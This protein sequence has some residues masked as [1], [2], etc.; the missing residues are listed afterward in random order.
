MPELDGTVSAS[1]TYLNLGEFNRTENDPTVIETFK[2]YEFAVTA[3]YATKLSAALGIGVNGRFIHSRLAPFG[4]AQEKGSGVSSGFSF[5]VGML[6]K[7]RSLEIP[8]T[9]LDIGNRFSL[10]LNLT[11]IVPVPHR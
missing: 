6:Y 10:G 8:F 4:T 2:G 11:N 3:G 5:D 9:G 7:P 1:I